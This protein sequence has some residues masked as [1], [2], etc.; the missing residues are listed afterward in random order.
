MASRHPATE[1]W[2][3]WVQSG[4]GSEAIK[5]ETLKAPADQQLYLI[6]RLWHAFMA[7]HAAGSTKGKND[8]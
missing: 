4:F 5:A 3:A 7:G 1:A 2:D 8:G 6:N